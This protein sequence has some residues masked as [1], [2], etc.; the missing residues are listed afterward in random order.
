VSAWLRPGGLRLGGKLDGYVGGLFLAANATSFLLVVGL[1]TIFNLASNLDWFE[2]WEDGA[3]APPFTILRY[4]LLETPFLYLQVAPFVT[5]MAGLFCVSRLVRHN[6]VVAALAAGVSARRVLL[7]V[8]AGGLLAAIGM[9]LLRELATETLGFKRDTLLDVLE[10]RREERVL[11]N[12]WFRDDYGNV[13]RLIEFRPAVGSPPRAEVRGLEVTLQQAG[14]SKLVRAERAVWTSFE[15]GNGWRL[16]GGRV[17]EVENPTRVHDTE[18]LEGVSFTPEEVL[19]LDKGRTRAM[20]LSFSELKRL[21][22]QDPGN[23]AYQTLLQY[24]LTFPLA[25]VVLLLVALPRMIGR[26]R[27]RALEG[28]V[29]GCLLCIFYFCLDFV[30]RAL[31]MEGSLSPLFASW[32]P[33]LSFGSLGVVLLEAMHT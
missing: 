29:E 4:Y 6:E 14:V 10:H 21:A 18:V 3:Y 13:V 22:L 5:V 15:G 7:P 17:Q 30:T 32:L 12:L 33:V 9:F 28:L 1:V 8:F 31:G 2:P 16:E 11:E 23:V 19:L 25:N 20:E 26:E 24:H 27:G